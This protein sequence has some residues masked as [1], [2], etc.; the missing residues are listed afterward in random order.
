MGALLAIDLGLHVGIA[1]FS[2][3]GELVYYRSHHLKSRRALAR[4]AWAT[5]RDVDGLTDVV[6]E[7]DRHLASVWRRAATKHGA[8]FTVVAPETWRAALL[9]PRDRR[10]GR[11]AKRRALKL[12]RVIVTRC[13]LV[14]RPNVRHD[15]AEAILIGQWAID[16][17][18]VQGGA[19]WA[20]HQK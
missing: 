10:S 13:G 17:S 4:L 16:A 14:W 8:S 7:G 5:V 9:I 19:P 3:A 18:R 2:T 6:V 1:L 12:A 20:I 11:A 15:A